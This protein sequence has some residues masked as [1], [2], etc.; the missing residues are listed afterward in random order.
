[1]SSPRVLLVVAVLGS[2]ALAGCKSTLKSDESAPESGE[3]A[4]AEPTAAVAQSAPASPAEA[5]RNEQAKSQP[6]TTAGPVS[7]AKPRKIIR[8]GSLLLEVE[9]HD[10]SR[11]AIDDLVRG[12]GGFVAAVEVG[13]DAGAAG[14]ATL[15]LR[16]PEARLDGAVAALA[17]LGTLRRESLRAED[18]SETYYDLAARLRNAKRLEERMLELAARAAGVKDLL[19]VEREVGR[20]RESIEVMEGQMR[21]LDDRTQLATL[22][23]ELVTRRVYVPEDEA[24]L[25]ARIGDA[26]DGSLRGLVATAEAALLF[27]VAAVPWLLPIGLVGLLLR[28]RLRRRV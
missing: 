25:A 8:T 27:L 26:F 5:N 23:V 18:V 28:R 15:T 10:K 17:R 3:V 21:V 14:S 24:G 13:R 7:P 12:A 19:E 11:A 2:L 22:T 9:D 16:L 6:D 4:V 1:M 20:V